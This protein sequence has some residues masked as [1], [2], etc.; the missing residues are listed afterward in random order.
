M[1]V[2]VCRYICVCVC[3]KVFKPELNDEKTDILILWCVRPCP[4][5]QRVDQGPVDNA[6]PSAS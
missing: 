2:C 5:A 6:P 3:R 1:C 4:L